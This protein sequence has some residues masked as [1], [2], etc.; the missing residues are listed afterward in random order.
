[1]RKTLFAILITFF[2]VTAWSQS[3]TLTLKTLA[4]K[5][6][7]GEAMGAV[8]VYLTSPG[9]TDT[10]VGESSFQMLISGNH[11]EKQHIV[12]FTVPRVKR[13]YS[14]IAEAVGYETIY[15]P[16][17]VN[18]IGKRTSVIDLP[19]LIFFAKVRELDEV[20]VTASKVKFY[21][22][23]DTLVY[24]AD[25][26]KLAEGSMLDELIRQLPGVEFRDDGGIY[27]NGKYVESLLLNGKDFF[28]SD[29]NIMLNN[30]G[31]YTVRDVAVY[32]KLGDK[33]MLA[34]QN[35]G[36]GQ[37]VMDVRLKREYMSG[38]T[39]NVEVGGGTSDRYLARLFGMW[40]TT[41]SRLSFIGALNNL[42][43]NRTPGRNDSWKPVTTAGDLRTKMAAIDYYIGPDNGNRWEF[44]GNTSVEHSRS[45]DI[46][47][48]N[49]VNF[50][51][52]GD[53]YENS[54]SKMLSHNL[55]VSTVNDFRRRWADKFISLSQNLK[56]VKNDRSGNTLSGAFN[57]K[58]EELTRNLLE[59]MFDGTAN[60]MV[61]NTVNTAL[62][63]SL[64]TGHMLNAGGSI[65]ASQ[66]MPG[67]PDL[68][69]IM[70][71][72]EYTDRNYDDFNLYDIRY[73]IAGTRSFSNQYIANAPDRSW[74]ISVRPSYEFIYSENGN[75]SAS[76]GFK[77][78]STTKD[79]YLYELDRLDEAGLFGQ[80]PVGYKNTLDD[81]RT[82]QS[83]EHVN[84]GSLQINAI[85]SGIQLA[86]GAKISYQILPILTFRDRT[87]DYRQGKFDTNISKRNV[88][89]EF[90]N[91][92]VLLRK[93]KDYYKLLFNRTTR[94]ADMVRMVDIVDSRD[95]LN[96]FTGAPDLKN[97]ARNELSAQWCHNVIGRHRWMD[98]IDLRYTFINNALV[99]GYRYNED[100][101][102]RT[103]RMYNI[104]G[105]YNLRLYNSLSKSFG[106]WDQFEIQSYTSVDYGEATDMVATNG[107]DMTRTKVKNLILLENAQLNWMIG[108]HK[109]SLNGRLNWRDTNGDRTGF[110]NFTATTA[111]YGAAAL[112]ALPHNFSL[113]T[114]LNLYTRRGFAYKELNTTDVVWNAR[115]SY[116]LKGGRWLFMLDGFDLLHQL[117]NVTYNV[118]AQGRTETFSNVLPRYF[119]FHVQYRIMIQPKKKN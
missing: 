11:E 35:L 90:Y 111:Q 115:L 19:D 91:T 18:H 6:L 72:G 95:P 26:F 37:Y 94:V 2:A 41:M 103:Y 85:N 52:G 63:R 92:Y 5:E 100:S 65:Y 79:S 83:Q 22:K 74:N 4:K 21:F 81:D 80:L 102:V 113:S 48:V 70:V 44:S 51:P 12:S 76:L 30:L 86:N 50:L 24:N 13:M 55:S 101:G 10:I 75:I 54:F 112:L 53:K 32:E 107:T 45:N 68:L 1:M 96:I 108:K 89:I 116:S 66:K 8:K 46:S 73:P 58:V 64:M 87:L 114:D 119:L 59:D 34:G 23:N 78:S 27:V 36:D 3:G 33:S 43:D 56:Y 109:M 110:A 29:R 69:S 38:Y 104:N 31:A 49:R 71:K 62:M 9:S 106:S 93:G 60:S 16:V 118:N 47:T 17:E 25:A 20:T 105:N 84:E 14:L 61:D 28:S 99:S 88:D 117:N 7:T 67:L 15:R 42:N 77:H 82:Y 40:Y 97:E 98:V 57:R 39:G